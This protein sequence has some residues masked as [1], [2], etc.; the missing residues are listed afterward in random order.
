MQCE[1]LV[2]GCFLVVHA[3]HCKLLEFAS[4]FGK[5]TV[6]INSD[7]YMQEKYGDKY[8]PLQNRAF[9]LECNKHVE[10]VVVFREDNPSEII[11]RLRPQYYVRGPDYAGVSLPEQNAIDSVQAKLIIHHADK[12]QDS[13]EVIELAEEGW[14]DSISDETIIEL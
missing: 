13:S 9:V 3:G 4:Q 1:V 5:V 7:K 2:S 8:I 12:I 10:N 14:F 11:K 6:A